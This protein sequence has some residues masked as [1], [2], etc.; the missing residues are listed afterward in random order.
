MPA[1]SKRKYHTW[2]ACGKLGS[3]QKAAHWLYLWP[4]ASINNQ[5]VFVQQKVASATGQTWILTLTFTV[6]TTPL[7]GF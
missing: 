4:T 7:R 1:T 3:V 5:V 2:F 6:V